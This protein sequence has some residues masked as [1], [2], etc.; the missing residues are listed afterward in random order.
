MANP[1]GCFTPSTIL[2]SNPGMIRDCWVETDPNSKEVIYC[3]RQISF[4]SNGAAGETKLIRLTAKE[5]LQFS[6]LI[7]PLKTEKGQS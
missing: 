2:R 3:I 1:T 6:C 5:A 4:D 7:Q